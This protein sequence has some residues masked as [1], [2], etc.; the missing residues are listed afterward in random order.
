MTFQQ[1]AGCPWPIS[2]EERM[3]N[4]K[5]GGRRRVTDEHVESVVDRLGW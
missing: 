3:E 2:I 4:L 5:V 1:A